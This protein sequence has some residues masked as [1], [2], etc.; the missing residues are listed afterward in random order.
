M[1][2]AIAHERQLSTV[3]RPTK[4][5]GLSARVNRLL[6]FRVAVERRGP[7]LAFP[8]DRNQFPV[9]RYR[10]RSALAQYSGLSGID[11]DGAYVLRN[12]RWIVARIGILALAV[13][14]VSAYVNQRVAVF[15]PAQLRDFAPVVVFIMRYLAAFKRGRSGHPDIADAAR[16]KYPSDFSAPAGCVKFRGERRSQN[17]FERERRRREHQPAKQNLKYCRTKGS[18]VAIR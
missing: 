15:A 7:D 12:S 10:G 17:L 4:R 5:A 1:V 11:R 3:G 18:H 13:G 8:R 14:A 6:G 9:R 2:P 16:I